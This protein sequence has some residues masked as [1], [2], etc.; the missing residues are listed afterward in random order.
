MAVAAGEAAGPLLGTRSLR[1]VVVGGEE[2]SLQGAIRGQH[3]D[4]APAQDAT[5]FYQCCEGANSFRVLSTGNVNVKSDACSISRG[6]WETMFLMERNVRVPCMF[7]W[8]FVCERENTREVVCPAHT[9]IVSVPATATPVNTVPVPV[10]TE[11]HGI[12]NSLLHQNIVQ[13]QDCKS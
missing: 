7:A 3:W 9:Q 11:R 10:W 6:M 12:K 1:A 2:R 5:N 13:S 4:R 8:V